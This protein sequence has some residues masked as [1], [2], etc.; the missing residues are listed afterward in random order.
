MSKLSYLIALRGGCG[1]MLRKSLQICQNK[2][3][4]LVTKLP[5]ITPT[6]VL[7][8]QC[9]WLSVNQLIFYHS[10][11]LVYKVKLKESP[12]YLFAMLKDNDY[13]YRT[14]QAV[15]NILKIQRPRLEVSKESFRWRA[16]E[17]YNRIPKEIRDEQCILS[18]KRKIKSWIL[19]NIPI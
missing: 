13:K 8:N 15:N 3:A 2:V 17:Q 19:S 6:S 16:A 10:V 12:K 11:L 7:L 9:G 18:F 1:I 4:R 5:W 14:R